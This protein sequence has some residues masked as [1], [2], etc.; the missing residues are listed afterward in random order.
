MASLSMVTN[1]HIKLIGT[2][3]LCTKTTKTDFANKHKRKYRWRNLI[4]CSNT[5]SMAKKKRFILKQS[6]ISELRVNYID[7]HTNDLQFAI[8]ATVLILM[9]LSVGARIVPLA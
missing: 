5:F 4:K 9:Q 7:K 2:V 3:T 6:C 8:Q 1:N